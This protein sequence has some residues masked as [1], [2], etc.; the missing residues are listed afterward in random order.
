[1]VALGI[2]PDAALDGGPLRSR[3]SGLRGEKLD[4]PS[5]PAEASAMFRNGGKDA[6]TREEAV[7][8]VE[9]ST[10]AVLAA[11]DS[12]TEE[13]AAS[14]PDSP[15]GPIPFAFWMQVPPMHMTGHARQ[16]DYIET[17]WGD[18]QDHR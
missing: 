10:S 4:M 14:S 5:D 18:V 3:E 15:F 2:G 7:K 9:D 12:I 6:K 11:L 13:R 16:L 17:I 1:M 8:S